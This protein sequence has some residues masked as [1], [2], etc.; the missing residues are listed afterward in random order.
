MCM[1][2]Y[3]YPYGDLSVVYVVYE[4]LSVVICPYG[5]LACMCMG[6]LYGRTCL[7][8]YGNGLYLY[9]LCLTLTSYRLV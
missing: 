9:G 3:P 1:G 8:V 5:G 7:Y 4:D 6:D 2:T